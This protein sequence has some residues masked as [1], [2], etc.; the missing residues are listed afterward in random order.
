MLRGWKV[1]ITISPGNEYQWLGYPTERAAR[2]AAGQASL[3]MQ[4]E[5]CGIPIQAIRVLPM[6]KCRGESGCM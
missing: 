3:H 6:W 4:K 1:R 2:E 5:F